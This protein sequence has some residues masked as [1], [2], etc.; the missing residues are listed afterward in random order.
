MSVWIPL[1]D[2]TIEKG[3]LQVIPHS[4]KW[5]LQPFTPQKDGACRL[6]IDTPVDLSQREYCPVQAGSMILFNS[7]L[8][9]ASEGNTTNRR[10][11]AFIVSY[12]EATVQGGN[13]A[14]W[15]ILR[16]A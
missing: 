8:W 16:P 5:G 12:Q 14:Q 4:H 9:H 3:C 13:G 15:Q 6:K 10:R 2:A 11:W 7:L 1:Q